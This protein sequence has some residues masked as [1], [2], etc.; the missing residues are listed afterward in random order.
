MTLTR[1]DWLA[2]AALAP[3]TVG[4]TARPARSALHAGLPDTA[5]FAATDLAYL[6]NG[7]Q[8]PIPL[9]SKAAVDAYLAKRTL[10]PGAQAYE[11]DEAAPLAKFARLINADPSEVTY[12]Q[13][14]TM[15]EQMVLRALGIPASGGH[16]VTDTLHFFGSLPL[17]EEMQRLGMEVTWLRPVEGRIRLE[18]VRA[19]VRKGTKL[20][21]LSQVSTINGFEHDVKSI[22]DVAHANGAMVYADIVHAAGCVPVDVRA[23]GVDFAACSSYKWL[24]GEFGL[25]FLYVRKD[26][27]ARLPRTNFGYYGIEKF[28]SHVQPLDPQGAGVADYVFRPDATGA[29]AIG[30]RSHTA[31]AQ[32]NASLD[33]ILELGVPTIQRHAQTLIEAIKREVPKRGYRMM[34]PPESRSPIATF[35]LADARRVLAAPMRDAKVRI[36]TSANRFRLTPS[37]QNSAAD[38]DR[39]LAALPKAI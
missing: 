11:L 29:F 39:F 18:D 34:T 19:A 24:M 25:G 21:A 9:R 27:L 7:S 20:V 2:A 3:I 26:V 14:T 28:V 6:D 15:G 4:A 35:I 8:H 16:I 31:I 12:V 32:L 36:T 38:L 1:R 5:S 17:Y 10:D 37:V 13:S 33:Y 22:C 30:T 23:T